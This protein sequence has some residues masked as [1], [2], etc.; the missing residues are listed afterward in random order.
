MPVNIFEQQ[1]R[2]IADPLAE[3]T[4]KVRRSLLIWCLISAALTVGGLFPVEI[5]LLGL[6]VSPTKKSVLLVIVGA[7][8][9]YFFL[10]FL[11]YGASDFA[12]WFFRQRSTQWEED[13]SN[14]EDYKAEL[15][16]KAKL[17]AEERMFMEDHERSLGSLWRGTEALRNY[18]R[19]EATTP[20]LSYSRALLDFGLPAVCSIA[21]IY[22]L[23][24]FRP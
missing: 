15:L 22:M 13:I 5:T 12:T 8:V 6:K 24:I 4:R 18:E 2:K 19:I 14:Y 11:I 10:T 16:G 3:E 1:L 7:I 17:T 23:V 21:A 20:F 9:I